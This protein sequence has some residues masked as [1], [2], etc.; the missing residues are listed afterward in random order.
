MGRGES[1]TVL[2]GFKGG[3]RGARR[4][5]FLRSTKKGRKAV[6]FSEEQKNVFVSSL[7]G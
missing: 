5:T 2:N 6:H 7:I 4:F 1:R 3:E